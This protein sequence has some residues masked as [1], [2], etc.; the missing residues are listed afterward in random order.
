VPASPGRALRE[1]EERRNRYKKY[2]AGKKGKKLVSK[3]KRKRTS[4]KRCCRKE[5]SF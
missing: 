1:K 5:R 2:V 4:I 3:E